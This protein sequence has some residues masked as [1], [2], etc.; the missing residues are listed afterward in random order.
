[1][2]P[3][4]K[5]F[6]TRI[7]ACFSGGKALTHALRNGRILLPAIQQQLAGHMWLACRPCLNKSSSKCGMMDVM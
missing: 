5:V 7:A 3:F 2:S 6:S 1:V 4:C